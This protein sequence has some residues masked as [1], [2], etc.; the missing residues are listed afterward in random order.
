MSKSNRQTTVGDIDAAI[1]YHLEE[2]IA[3][4]RQNSNVASGVHQHLIPV[5]HSQHLNAP[6]ESSILAMY[7]LTRGLIEV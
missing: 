2:T 4:I 5:P 1:T 3:Y 7:C 6:I